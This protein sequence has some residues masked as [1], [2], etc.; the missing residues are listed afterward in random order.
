MRAVSSAFLNSLSGSTLTTARVR[1]VD[2]T[3]GRGGDGLFIPFTPPLPIISGSI[4]LDATADERARVDDL[5]IA[6]Y[7]PDI[8]QDRPNSAGRFSTAVTELNIIGT[9]ASQRP[10]KPVWPPTREWSQTGPVLSGSAVIGH[11][12][13][14][15]PYGQFLVIE[16]G[17]EM[18]NGNVE[19]V[20]LGYYRIESMEQEDEPDGPITIGARD[21]MAS[22]IDSRMTFERTFP[23]GTTM[24]AIFQ[25]LL[26]SDRG[27]PFGWEVTDLIL[28]GGF[29]A[30][31]LAVARTTER[32]RFEFLDGLVKERG[33]RWYADGKGRIV[34]DQAPNPLAP[35]WDVAAGAGGSLLRSGR[36]VT[37][38]GVYNIAVADA[39]GVSDSPAVRAWRYNFEGWDSPTYVAAFG[40]VPAFYESPTITDLSSAQAAADTVYAA[41]KG[42]PYQ[43][44]LVTIPNP[45]LEPDDPIRVYPRG[46][47]DS[48]DYELHIAE[49][50]SIPLTPG[51]TMTIRTREHRTT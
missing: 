47:R 11:K 6:P 41:N 29:A 16:A 25:T 43:R 39:A 50:L 26:I 21:L 23:S 5:T 10:G 4:T 49:Q 30:D 35:V 24:A 8:G 45:A 22:V 36:K 51:G 1:A 12:P 37:R 7:W 38:D 40:Y 28:D 19:Y 31:T 33:Y 13:P 15:S 17:V 46:T 48:L 20:R 14:L 44:T 2:P 9:Q 18:G 3:K 27:L 32:E 42:V 34:V